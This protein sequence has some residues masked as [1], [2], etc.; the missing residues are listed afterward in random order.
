V[1]RWKLEKSDPS[2]AVS[3]PKE[4]IVYYIDRSIPKEYRK[5]VAEGA[6]LWNKAFEKIGFKDAVVVKEAPDDPSWDTADVRYSSIRWFVSTDASFAIGPSMADPRTG[7]LYDADIGFSESMT[8]ITRREYREMAD[9]LTMIR[10]MI[11]ETMATAEASGQKLSSPLGRDA[12]RLCTIGSEAY[13]QASF[14]WGI[15][16][17]RGTMAPGSAEEER[18]VHDFLVS[19]TAH[20]VGHTLGLRHNYR[21]SSLNSLADLQDASKTESTGLTGSVMEYTPVNIA[22]PG[23]K[24]GQ[25]WQTT[26]GP[27]DYWAIEYAYKPISAKTPEEELPELRRIASK[28]AQPALAF[29]TDDD[30]GFGGAPVGM[31][32]RDNVWDIGSDPIGFFTGRMAIAREL[33]KG[34][35]DKVM[36]E[37]DGYQ[38]VRRAFNQGIGEFPAA[39]VS[40][41]K[42]V[43]GVMQN[44]DHVGDPD[45]RR[46][47]V[48][49][50]ATEQRRALAFLNT[51]LFAADAFQFKPELVDA[52]SRDRF[53]P[54]VGFV[55]NPRQD[56]PV[57]E[58]VLGL[59]DLALTRLYHPVL[60]GR[61]QDADTRVPNGTDHLSMA[62]MF[63][64]LRD[65]IWTELRPAPARG[66]ADIKV[67]KVE[68]NSYRRALQRSH[69]QRIARLAMGMVPNEPDSAATL[70]RADLMELKGRIGSAL[71]VPGL[72]PATRAHLTESVALI[73]QTL[74]AKMIRSI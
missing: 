18:Y 54:L 40:V 11:A 45:G 72:D 17:A 19:V 25:Y 66:P 13:R 33:W 70:A 35:P 34:L 24:Q 44:R 15:L 38:I 57:H 52:M 26:L 30:A 69:L 49:I 71:K 74:D 41:T 46:P 1:D 16:A 20:E 23:S 58:T 2:A 7:R 62:E 43:G 60:L 31:D 67:P 37:G 32:P 29:S 63:A 22:P 51:H 73:D 8:R 36:E 61:V 50:P 5:A 6:L 12:S 4:P 55:P 42:Y 9:P 39:I 3:A 14:G 68:V 27:Y 56:Y 10:S 21:A 47:Y 48:P 65:G 64:T 59:Q 53:F 28:V